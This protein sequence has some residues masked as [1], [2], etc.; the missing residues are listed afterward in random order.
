MEL[1]RQSRTQLRPPAAPVAPPTPPEG[2]EAT[3]GESAA[4]SGTANK[5]R[6]ARRSGAAAARTRPP[7]V[8]AVP[9]GAAASGATAPVLRL[10]PAT[11]E[12]IP[13]PALPAPTRT[14]KV[15]A[16]AK[17]LMDPEA[18]V[19][20]RVRHL[21]AAAALIVVGVAGYLLGSRTAGGPSGQVVAVP[22]AT[23]TAAA[24][25]VPAT[26]RSPARTTPPVS[27][28]AARGTLPADTRAAARTTPPPRQ[29]ATAP[30]TTPAIR[31]AANPPTGAAGQPVQAAP[32]PTQQVAAAPP[33]QPQPAAAE[34]APAAAAPAPSAARAVVPTGPAPATSQPDADLATG[35]WSAVGREEA[36]QLLGGAIGVIPG[37]HIESITRSVTG[38]RARVRIVQIT[39][40]GERIALT[41]T[42]AGAAVRGAGPMAVTALR[43]MPASEAYPFSTGTV[44]FGNLLITVKT[45]VPVDAL[46]PLLQ[47]IAEY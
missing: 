35:G 20:I 41:E 27:E 22:P 21:V 47:R 24:E 13:A 28:P 36:A 37:L 17:A 23:E 32:T 33:P 14:A 34:P 40:A 12:G 38:S 43:V 5:A 11:P 45:T 1:I 31:Q 39:S 2:S 30:P 15:T 29:A 10:E 19:V 3:E 16:S 18:A 4:A 6:A 25:P 7:G 9:T 42:R 44:S 26:T 46:Q 8:G